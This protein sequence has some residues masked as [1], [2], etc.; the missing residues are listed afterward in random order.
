M[1]GV[2]LGMFEEREY[3]RGPDLVIAVEACLHPQLSLLWA[4]VGSQ[5]VHAIQIKNKSPI[6]NL[7]STTN[8]SSPFK[9]HQFGLALAV[10]AP[11]PP[12]SR[13]NSSC[14]PTRPCAGA[15]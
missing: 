1:A 2:P 3:L 11:V 10:D 15:C 14:V 5:Q 7:Q 9:D 4:D 6:D 12:T 8:H 13:M